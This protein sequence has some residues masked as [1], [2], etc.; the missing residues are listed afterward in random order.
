MELQEKEYLEALITPLLTH[1]EDLK[2]ER[3][4]DERGILLTI[5]VK[6]EDMGRIL[7]KKGE[8]ANALRRLLRQ[9]GATNQAL[10]SVKIYEPDQQHRAWKSEKEVLGI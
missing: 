3:I 5:H 6:Q 8:T 4:V 9:Y 7:G 1:P 10:V 2:V